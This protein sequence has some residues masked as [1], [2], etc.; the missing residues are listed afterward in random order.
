MKY[1]KIMGLAAIAAAALM[2]FVGASSASATVYC[3]TNLTT[4]CAAAGWDYPA[5]T[6]IHATSTNS[7]KLV[8]GGITLDT[9][10]GST[11]KGKT[12]NTGSSTETVKG[13]I[14]I[15]NWGTCT[16]ETKTI[17]LGELETHWI[18]GTDNATLTSIG[19]EV[20]VSTVFGSCVYSASDLGTEV[21][22]NPATIEIKE[23]GVKLVSGPCPAETKWTQSFT[24]TEPKPL[25]VSTN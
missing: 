16:N 5:G 3:K 12:S 1:L 20:T 9:C 19:T 22:G 13:P 7:G 25:F 21:G 4:G 18:S 6:V 11:I 24:I 10:T 15:L 17:K 8:A 2:A 23:L 14:E